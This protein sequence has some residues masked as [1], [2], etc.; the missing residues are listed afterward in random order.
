MVVRERLY[1]MLFIFSGIMG[2]GL[3]QYLGL[4]GE[5]TGGVIALI[6]LVAVYYFRHD[7]VGNGPSKSSE[8]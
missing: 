4:N 8:N 7:G 1:G 5:L 3:F 6:T 2:L